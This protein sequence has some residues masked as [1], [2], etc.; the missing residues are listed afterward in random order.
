MSPNE[1]TELIRG[2]LCVFVNPPHRQ[3]TMPLDH[4][5]P[6]DLLFRLLVAPIRRQCRRYSGSITLQASGECAQ[7]LVG[8][9]H[10]ALGYPDRAL[11][12]YDEGLRVTAR[13]LGQLAAL[14][15]RR[16]LLLEHRRNLSASWQ[17]VHR[18]EFDLEVLRGLLREGEGAYDSA[19]E[20]YR[21]ARKL[22]EQLNDDALRA[23]A[24]RQLAAVYGRRQQLEEAVAHAAQSVAIYERLGD[25]VNLEK[26]RSNMAFIYVQTRQFQAALEVGE[27]AYR[28][29]VT[30]RDP[31]FA[32]VTAANLAEAS[33]EL[34]DLGSATR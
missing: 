10:N 33:C 24:E 31:Y 13:L 18:A 23:Q 9:L 21:R 2:D 16:G 20:A 17:E 27:L 4:F 22:A 34:G 11:A 19:L 8:E 3:K 12:S 14:H 28:F 25:R 1:G 26:M 5:Q 15:Q 29:F 7:L 6:V 32:A 30:V